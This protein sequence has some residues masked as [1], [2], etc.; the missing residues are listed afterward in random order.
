M[1]CLTC[2]IQNWII[3]N[4]GWEYVRHQG[5][6]DTPHGHLDVVKT[7]GPAYDSYGVV[8]SSKLFIILKLDG[9]PV[10]FFRKEG[11]TDSYNDPVWDGTFREVQ[12]VEK[13]VTVYEWE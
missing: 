5:S 12:A 7:S 2:D 4:K 8:V 1:D 3:D 10:R 6:V 9:V 11:E 13:T